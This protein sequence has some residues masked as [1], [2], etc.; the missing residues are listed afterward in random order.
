MR[1]SIIHI[2]I[3]EKV[4]HNSTRSCSLPATD[5]REGKARQGKERKKNWQHDLVCIMTTETCTVINDG[6]HSYTDG[7]MQNCTVCFNIPSRKSNL[8]SISLSTWQHT[9]HKSLLCL[10]PKHLEWTSGISQEIVWEVW[11][12]RL[13]LETV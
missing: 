9:L 7:G 13:H 11:T 8:E 3:D 10:L 4:L 6:L 5:E 12:S 2:F 1:S